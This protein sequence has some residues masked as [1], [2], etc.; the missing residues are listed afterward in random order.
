MNQPTTAAQ[1]ISQ[2]FEAY[3][4]Q[5]RTLAQVTAEHFAQRRWGEVRRNAVARL[6]L[7]NEAV[8]GTVNELRRALGPWIENRD[9]WPAIKTAYARLIAGRVD[10]E[11]GETFYNSVTRRLFRTVGV[12]PAIEF[13]WFDPLLL[14]QGRNSRVTVSYPFDSFDQDL[15]GLVTRL[16]RELPIH[17]A[18]ADL[19][20][21]ATRVAQSIREH[22]AQVWQ[23][24]HFETLEILRPVFY[25]GKAAYII[26][27][28]VRGIRLQPFALALLHE[29]E[30]VVVDATLL[31]EREL[32]ILF[33]FT[34]AYFHVDTDRPSHV[35]GFLHTIMPLKPIAE[36]YIALGYHKHGKTVLYRDLHRHLRQTT[37]R[38]VVAPGTKGMVMAVFTLPSYEIVFK[39]IK[40]RF[41]SPKSAT[42]RQVMERYK[43]VFHHDRV[44]RLMD[45]QEFEHLT[46]ARER[47][48]PLLLEELQQVASQ[49]V[50]AREHDVV[51]THVYTQR[52]VHPLDLYLKEVSPEKARA[53]VIDYGNAIKELAAANIFP[54]DLLIKNFGVTRNGRVVFYDYDELCLLTEVNF[55]RLP[56]ATSYEDELA[57]EPWFSVG[58]NDVFPEEFRKFLGLPPELQEVMEEVHGDLFTP[59]FWWTMQ[60]RIKAEEE[61]DFYPYG[62]ERR[63]AVGPSMLSG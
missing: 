47:F 28:L 10:E 8:Q 24:D 20:R 23:S 34:H 37:D 61:P 48:D 30:G 62:E 58:P 16:L 1:I 14:P 44:G 4:A 7:Y 27:R 55:R 26:G 38:F 25:R 6:D 59:E 9:H 43:L 29:P 2:A 17:A 53:A 35:V 5:F 56:P 11:I 21:D 42:R 3:H 18:Y 39:V 41:T 49:A 63:Y 13:V 15:T 51:L 33:S 31:T 40:D 22:M 36:L 12:D 52:R 32:S 57:A 60:E 54:G 45:A 46:L 19:P 50:V